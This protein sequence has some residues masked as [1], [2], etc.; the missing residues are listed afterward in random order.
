MG[1]QLSESGS[2]FPLGVNNQTVGSHK[3]ETQIII[4]N[5]TKK[6]KTGIEFSPKVVWFSLLCLF[7]GKIDTSFF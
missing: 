6:A 7:F 4:S 1:Q 5:Q 2:E 3:M